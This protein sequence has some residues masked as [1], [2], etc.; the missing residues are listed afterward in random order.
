MVKHS[1]QIQR[2][3][4]LNGKICNQL[5]ITQ[6]FSYMDI[7][8]GKIKEAKYVYTVVECEASLLR[9]K[10]SICSLLDNL[11]LMGQRTL[12][13]IEANHYY[14][15]L[16]PN[17]LLLSI[18]PLKKD[19]EYHRKNYRIYILH[20]Y[21]LECNFIELNFTARTLKDY[22][23]IYSIF[24]V[25]PEKTLHRLRQKQFPIIINDV[26]GKAQEFIQSKP[27]IQPLNMILL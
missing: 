15:Y 1:V 23:R 2:T 3:N 14:K 19:L 18:R 5:D 6:D 17:R 26:Y 22:D 10:A 8:L 11:S 4:S 20:K 12:L 9:E 24:D 27:P 25:M 13:Y 21:L 16:N 7:A